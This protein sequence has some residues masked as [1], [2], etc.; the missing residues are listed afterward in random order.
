M[1]IGAAILSL[2]IEDYLGKSILSVPT[3]KSIEDSYENY[4]TDAQI[5]AM[6]P[7]ID[8]YAKYTTS[9][10]AKM[11][12]K[13]SDIIRVSVIESVTIDELRRNINSTINE[14][15]S[16]QSLAIARTV[17]GGSYNFARYE[18]FGTTGVDTHKWMS[19][20]DLE[21]RQPHLDET[22]NQVAIGDP[23]P[24]TGLR[25][26]LDPLGTAAQV[27]NCRCTTFPSRVNAEG[28]IRGPKETTHFE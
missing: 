20:M 5:E 26:P 23:F 7:I 4:L 24:V 21:V 19:A 1:Y 16:G 28:R 10:P 2:E 17:T 18:L 3:I 27:V 11:V 6:L 9:I 13:V 8:D 12:Q 14:I 25:Y 15:Y 22:G